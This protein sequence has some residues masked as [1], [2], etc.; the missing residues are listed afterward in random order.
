MKMARDDHRRP[1]VDRQALP[2]II[3]RPFMVVIA[4]EDS[5]RALKACLGNKTD[6]DRRWPRWPIARQTGGCY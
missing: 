6:R 4:N 5:L 3:T 1:P 2:S